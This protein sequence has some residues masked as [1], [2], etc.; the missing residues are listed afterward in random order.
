VLIAAY[1]DSDD[2]WTLTTF[3]AVC[4]GLGDILG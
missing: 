3:P 1:K 2:W 4:E